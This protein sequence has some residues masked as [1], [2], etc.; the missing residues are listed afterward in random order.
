[1]TEIVGRGFVYDTVRRRL[2]LVVRLAAEL[3]VTVP[4]DTLEGS[5][6]LTDAIVSASQST[7]PHAVSDAVYEWLT[8]GD[9]LERAVA[10]GTGGVATGQISL[11]HAHY[12]NVELDYEDPS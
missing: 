8:S 3:D 9:V 1:M 2:R 12:V 5:D 10:Q 6:D 4:V 7:V 11:Q